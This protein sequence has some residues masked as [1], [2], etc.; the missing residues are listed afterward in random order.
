MDSAIRGLDTF[1]WLVFTSV[2]GVESFFSRLFYLGG[3][4]RWLNGVKIC[5]IGPATAREV[6][7]HCI[8]VDCQPSKYVAEEVLEELKRQAPGG[9]R[10]KRVVIPRADIARSF[11]P[12][13]LEKLGAE[14]VELVAYRTVLAEPSEQKGAGGREKTLLE[15]LK[16]GE[17]DVVTF[18]SSSTV[19]NF[20][21]IVGKENV[22]ALDGKVCFASIGPITTKTAQELGLK[23]TIE[24]K[25]YTIP[26]LVKAVKEG[27]GRRGS[28][29]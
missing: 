19:R 10:G 5:A 11:L 9:L 6:E 18:T 23:I 25:E 26:G 12:E 8:K 20:V 17:I 13:E 4:A 24:A 28:G 2:N 22:G 27:L 29:I 15:K 1:H 21:E 7:R 14:V 16:R 3:D